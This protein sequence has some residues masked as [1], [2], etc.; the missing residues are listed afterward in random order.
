[1]RLEFNPRALCYNLYC[2]T[3]EEEEKMKQMLEK[4]LTATKLK[5]ID[6]MIYADTDSVR[7]VMKTKLNSVYGKA[8]TD[9]AKEYIVVHQDK[10]PLIIFL[11]H[12]QAIKQ[13]V[14]N[15]AKIFV[16]DDCFV[17][18]EKYADVIKQIV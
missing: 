9:M 12:I 11:Q 8:V 15:Q 10:R 7:N 4:P 2:D 18:D 14:D 5:S 1:M 6:N 17:T 13:G 16:V 3:R